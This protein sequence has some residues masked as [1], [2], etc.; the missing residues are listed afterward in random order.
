MADKF[1]VLDDATG[2]E[3]LITAT[4]AGALMTGAIIKTEYEGE[5]ET[6]AFDDDAVTKLGGIAASATI[7]QTGPAIKTAYEAEGSAFTDAQF[8]KLAILNVKKQLHIPLNAFLDAVT[9]PGTPLTL[10]ADG[11][12]TLPG[13]SIV[14]TV[15][16]GIRWN[17]HVTPGDIQASIPMPQDLD[18]TVDITLHYLVSK[19]GAD[20]DDD[21]SM[22]SSIVWQTPGAV[23]DVDTPVPDTSSALAG[24]DAA[25]TVTELVTTIGNADIPASPSSMNLIIHPTDGLLDVDDCILL[26]MWIEYTAKA[27][28]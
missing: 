15:A 27:V 19:T 22:D 12:T 14:D 26:A 8:T 2:K 11:E 23:H 7:D 3:K 9:A 6:N 13:F 17:D 4:Q 18:E 25:K 1:K 5:S 24:D 16:L 28:A 10:F 21:V 20:A